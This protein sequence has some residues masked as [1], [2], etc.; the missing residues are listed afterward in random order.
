MADAAEVAIAAGVRQV[1]VLGAGFDTLGL[2]LL[3][4]HAG[5]L[6]VELDRPSTLE[7][8]TEALSSAGISRP[9]PRFAAVDLGEKTDFLPALADLGWRASDPTYFVAELVLEYLAP[10]AATAVL[11][12]IGTHAAPGS[13]LACTV[14]FGDH[15]D[16]H[17]ASATAAVGEPMRFRPLA[18]ELP[19]LLAQACFDVLAQRGRVRGRG[20]G[21]AALLLLAPA[22]GDV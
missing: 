18:A 7:A 16:D 5:L 3:R 4:A 11:T 8:K 6:V 17:L 12:A 15:A 14:R 9:W 2:Q 1:A 10:E 22:G 19:G 20:G 21:A 13:R